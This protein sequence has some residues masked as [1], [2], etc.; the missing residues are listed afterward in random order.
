M[1]D[2]NEWR[3]SKAKDMCA[4]PYNAKER[5]LLGFLQELYGKILINFGGSP[6]VDIDLFI[7]TSRANNVIPEVTKIAKMNSR[8]VIIAL[9]HH[10]STFNPLDLVY[11]EMEIMESI[12]YNAV[13]IKQCIEALHKKST[14][15][16]KII[17]HH[18]VLDDIDKAFK[19]AAKSNETLKIL[20]DHE[21]YAEGI[22]RDSF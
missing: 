1:V 18:Y 15:V 19:Q 17:T 10:D 13:D 22:L 20:I 7:D 6:V 12:A 11:S 3:L 8:L 4:I 5:N 14:P 9:Y 16:E 21:Y 2:I